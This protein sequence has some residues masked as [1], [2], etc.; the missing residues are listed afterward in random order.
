MIDR[1]AL[2]ALVGHLD[3]EG[4]EEA[5]WFIKELLLL[6]TEEDQH[7]GRTDMASGSDACVE[8]YAGQLLSILRNE[9]W[10]AVNSIINVLDKH[11]P[12]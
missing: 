12:V 3:L 6:G 5:A 11:V 10:F 8:W 9:Q 1:V 4:P 7:V 2:R